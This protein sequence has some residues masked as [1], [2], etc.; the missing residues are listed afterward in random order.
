MLSKKQILLIVLL[1]II[2]ITLK[3]KFKKKEKLGLITGGT[4]TAPNFQSDYVSHELK[5]FYT[6]YI[7]PLL[8]Y[9][10]DNNLWQKINQKDLLLVAHQSMFLDESKKYP[11]TSIND[12]EMSRQKAKCYLDKT[13]NNSAKGQRMGTESSMVLDNGSKRRA[14]YD[15]PELARLDGTEGGR[16]GITAWKTDNTGT[17]LVY[18][19]AYNQD[20]NDIP[21]VLIRTKSAF[22]TFDNSQKNILYFYSDALYNKKNNVDSNASPDELIQKQRI[23]SLW[24]FANMKKTSEPMTD[25]QI[26][27]KLAGANVENWEKAIEPAYALLKEKFISNIYQNF[28]CNELIYYN[29]PSYKYYLDTQKN[30]DYSVTNINNNNFLH[31]KSV[32]HKIKQEIIK[33]STDIIKN[34]VI[35]AEFVY[36]NCKLSEQAIR[37]QSIKILPNLRLSQMSNLRY[38]FLTTKQIEWVKNNTSLTLMPESIVFI[39]IFTTD[40]KLY[41][42]PNLRADHE[43]I[44]KF[45]NAQDISCTLTE[46]KTINQIKN[47]PHVSL[48]YDGTYKEYEAN[49]TITLQN[50]T[51]ETIK[52]NVMEMFK[53][54]ITKKVSPPEIIKTTIINK[55]IVS[56]PINLTVFENVFKY[57]I[58]ITNRYFTF[59]I[60]TNKNYFSKTYL[61]S[62]DINVSIDLDKYFNNENI[63]NKS[64]FTQFMTKYNKI[65]I[66]GKLQQYKFNNFD[67]SYSKVANNFY[68][69]TNEVGTSNF[70]TLFCYENNTN[71]PDSS[72]TVIL[73]YHIL[74]NE[75]KYNVDNFYIKS[76]VN[77]IPQTIIDYIPETYF[78]QITDSS[79][80]SITIDGDIYYHNL[81]IITN[82]LN[83]IKKN[84]T[85]LPGDKGKLVLCEFVLKSYI[86]SNSLKTEFTHYNKTCVFE[87]FLYNS[88]WYIKI[89]KPNIDSGIIKNNILNFC[90]INFSYG[91]PSTVILKHDIT[92]NR[93]NTNDDIIYDLELY[94]NMCNY[95]NIVINENRCEVFKNKYEIIR[96]GQ[97]VDKIFKGVEYNI[98][99]V[100]NIIQVEYK[101]K[102]KNTDS[103]IKKV[104]YYAKFPMLS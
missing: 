55:K 82:V 15:D 78:E 16:A 101:A 67:T 20:G 64:I 35:L 14:F 102:D 21:L 93:S 4:F 100:E 96:Y 37:Q 29:M 5:Y 52:N 39:F 65:N 10:E 85:L 24:S 97:H 31:I 53:Y 94:N 11:I 51:T 47:V 34:K 89:Q 90:P 27:L 18:G 73:P 38:K 40:G 103:F 12:L 63:N 9:H 13:K 28:S 81:K 30:L 84:I 32:A 69:Y 7:F 77:Y 62:K 46:T 3:I 33:N 86:K 48:L 71:N 26:I 70:H 61:N 91:I 79:G 58:P 8:A 36:N 80:N 45:I 98:V 25:L 87:F 88:N 17:P 75:S 49:I 60:Y 72:D 2:I 104:A 43:K 74:Y 50:G 68:F 95:D 44:E 59:G 19:P 56:L 99:N 1:L 41:G 76:N 66:N 57:S 54:K 22:G 83:E 42:M 92:R 23:Y 6:P